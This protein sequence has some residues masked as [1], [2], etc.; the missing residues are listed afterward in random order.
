M[1]YKQ[2]GWNPFTKKIDPVKKPVGPVTPNTRADYM[3]REVFNL[4][5]DQERNKPKDDD[6]D[7]MTP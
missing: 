6:S 4:V 1:A 7:K 2:K 5:Q 3:A